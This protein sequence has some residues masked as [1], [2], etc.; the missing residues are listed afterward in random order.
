MK[1]SR[2]TELD[3]DKCVQQAGGNRFEMVLMAAVRARD[4]QKQ[5]VASGKKDHCHSNVAALLDIQSGLVKRD[6]LKRVK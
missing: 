3:N 5:H 4:I 1:H 6:I 2:G